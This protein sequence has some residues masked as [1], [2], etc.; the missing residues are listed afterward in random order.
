MKELYHERRCELAF[1]YTNYLF[2][3]KRWTRSSDATIK[4]IALAELN[5]QSMIRLHDDC[6][7]PNSAYKVIEYQG[8]DSKLPY[9]DG[10]MT[11]PYP[12]LQVV[13]ANGALKQLPYYQ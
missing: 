1:E 6:K 2:D 7:D 4:A 8:C 9:V 13:N 5:A 3:L 12:S 10:M 11:F